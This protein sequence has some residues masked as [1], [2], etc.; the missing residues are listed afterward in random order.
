MRRHTK[1]FKKHKR[2]FGVS[3]TFHKRKTYKRKTRKTKV[4]GGNGNECPVCLEAVPNQCILYPCK[5]HICKSCLDFLI[6]PKKCPLC[7]AVIFSAN[8]NGQTTSYTHPL[9]VM[10]DPTIAKNIQRLLPYENWELIK[11]Q[12][13]QLTFKYR[14]PINN[15]VK[16]EN[17]KHGIQQLTHQLET[18]LNSFK[19]A[20]P[21]LNNH[22]IYIT[23]SVKRL[24]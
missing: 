4:R 2:K 8:C 13:E 11:T 16:L 12:P 5:H 23:L 15:P 6:N 19:Y 7:R 10:I 9:P 1:R 24:N 20:Y 18:Q 14:T 21:S 17:M 22:M 3:G